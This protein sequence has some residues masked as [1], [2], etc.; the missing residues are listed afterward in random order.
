MGGGD[1]DGRDGRVGEKSCPP[2]A[3]C[4][5]EEPREEDER[6]MRLALRHAALAA[7]GGEVPVGAVLV[8]ENGT[9]VAAGRNQV[10]HRCDP[11]AHAEIMAVREGCRCLD[12]WR[13]LNCTLYTTVEPCTMCLSALLAARV[14]RLVYGSPDVRLG[15]VRSWVPLLEKKH[16]FHSIAVTEGVLG[17]E[18]QSM[19]VNFFRGRRGELSTDEIL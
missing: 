6:F 4:R 10:E 12:N 16:P 9:V 17:E 18:A 7:E 2:L 13:L 1:G 11:T 14:S 5:L 15:G 19:M 8:A 3:G